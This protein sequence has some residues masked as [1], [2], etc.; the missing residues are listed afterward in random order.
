MKRFALVAF[1]L[2]L[3]GLALAAP[4]EQDLGMGLLYFRVHTLPGDL[5]TDESWRRHPCILDLRYVQGDAAATAALAGWFK[6][7]S[8]ART[9]VILLAN[10]DTSPGLLAPFASAE[11]AVGLIIVGRAASDFSPDIAV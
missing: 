3:L 8:G 11:A 7:H 4:V 5:P 1:F 9:P 10:S 6:F 2:S